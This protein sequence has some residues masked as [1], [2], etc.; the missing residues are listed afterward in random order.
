[1]AEPDHSV[2]LGKKGTRGQKILVAGTVA[3]VLLAYLT[4]RKTKG[5]GSSSALP[6]TPDPV[7][8]AATQAADSGGDSSAAAAVQGLQDQLDNLTSSQGTGAWAGA[9]AA[10]ASQAN[11]VPALRF[12]DIYT[13]RPPHPPSEGVT[14][15][16]HPAT[17]R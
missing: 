5:S 16:S 9:S 8:P 11:W 6:A 10:Q 7:I 17:L 12:A 2:V 3:L 4:L 1:M 13:V 15:T 14:Y